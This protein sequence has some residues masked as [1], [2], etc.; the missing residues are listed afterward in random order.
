MKN[1]LELIKHLLTKD[2]REERTGV[3]ARSAFG[4]Q[5]HFDLREGFPLLGAKRTPFKAVI[6]ELLWFLSGS[7]NVK[8]LQA[9]NCSIWDEWADPETGELGPIYGSMWRGTHDKQPIDQISALVDTLKRDPYSR[10]H[11]VSSWIPELLPRSGVAPSKQPAEGRQALPPCHTMFQV[12]M[13]QDPVRGGFFMDLQLYQRSADMF[14]GVPFNIASYS[15]L[16]MMLADQVGA[17]PRAFVHTLGDYHL[18]ENHVEGAREMV[19]REPVPL[20]WL[21]VA[22][23][24]SIFSY[25]LDHFTLGG[26]EPHPAIKGEVAV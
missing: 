18:Y 22:P 23:A 16:L 19:S 3:T 21:V 17:T 20:P 25:T 14:L 13:D 11:L 6:A 7:T 2:P 1:Y 12:Y 15:A 10:R 9:M 24:P 26:Y 8:D 4:A 5:M